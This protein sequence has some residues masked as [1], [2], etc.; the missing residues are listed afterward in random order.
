ML[1]ERKNCSEKNE[2]LKDKEIQQCAA[3]FSIKC[4]RGSRKLRNKIGVYG[5]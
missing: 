5:W 1:Q 2:K 3:Q 4:W